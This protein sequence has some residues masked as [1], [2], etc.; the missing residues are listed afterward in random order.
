MGALAA[1]RRERVVTARVDL[2]VNS[3]ERTYRDVLAPG[4]FA[5]ICEHNPFPFA[6]RTALINNVDDPEDAGRRAQ[7]LIDSGELEA[8]EFVADHLERG[9]AICGLERSDLGRVPYF[10]DWALAAI[11]LPG[12]DWLLHWDAELR[13]ARPI[14]WI[15]PSIELMDRDRRVLL[16]NPAWGDEED[17]R[18]HTSE[19]V[20][21]F[22]LG[23]GFSDQVFLA[24]RSDLAQ[25]IYAERTIA[26]LRYPVAHLGYIFEARLDSYMRRHGRLRATYVPATWVHQ[27]TMGVKYPKRSLRETLLYARN[28]VVAML[29]PR[30]PRPL[31]P[32]SLRNL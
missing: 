12:P 16:A 2:V 26:R 19:R 1:A 32:P 23:H 4:T 3:Y 8:F 10:T 9:L 31:R 6:R 14:D 17:L 22:A 28:R 25:P 11:V 13:L 7:A 30:I 27:S 20:G 5:R 24:R 15:S 18:R 21:E 29:L